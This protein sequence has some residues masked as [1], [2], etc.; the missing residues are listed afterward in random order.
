MKKYIIQT[1]GMGAE[2]YIHP[3]TEEQ[4]SQIV[5][6]GD[7]DELRQEDF[8]Q[9]LNMEVIDESNNTI[10]GMYWDNG[11]YY[12]TI[13]DEDNNEVMVLDDNWYP[14]EFGDMVTVCNG[15]EKYFIVE[16]SIKGD[17]QRYILET[18]EE[19]DVEKLMTVVTEIAES[20][21]L[22]SGLVYDGVVLETDKENGW[23]DYWGKGRYFYIN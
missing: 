2:C 5:E 9:I 10:S 13:M 3:I 16:D 8:E 4:H 1:G 21:W 14:D 20:I 17:F 19:F 7:I 15:P 22:V 18:E 23:G 11:A 12:V 6:R